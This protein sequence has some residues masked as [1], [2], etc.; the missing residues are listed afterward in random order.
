MTKVY[1]I[2]ENQA[3][4]DS[5]EEVFRKIQNNV[6]REGDVQNEGEEETFPKTLQAVQGH[7]QS[8]DKQKES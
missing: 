1:D 3:V 5:K 2:E 4:L 8:S 6:F 7:G